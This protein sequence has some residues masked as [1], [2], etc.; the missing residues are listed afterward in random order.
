[1]TEGTEGTEG[2]TGGRGERRTTWARMQIC[3]LLACVERVSEA[4]WGLEYVSDALSRLL[5]RH[6]LLRRDHRHLS[7]RC[8]ILGRSGSPGGVGCAL[9]VMWRRGVP[10]AVAGMDVGGVFHGRAIRQIYRVAS[11]PGTNKMTKDSGRGGW[12]GGLVG[13]SEFLSEPTTGSRTPL[14]EKAWKCVRQFE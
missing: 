5:Q 12:S 6:Q 9:E 11:V 1:M 3:A 14:G 7:C 2:T 4:W 8:A 13:L 10:G